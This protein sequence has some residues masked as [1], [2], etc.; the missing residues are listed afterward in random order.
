MVSEAIERFL[1][2]AV[3]REDNNTKIIF[4]I[5]VVSR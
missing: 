2:G 4:L 1:C 5:T 3:F